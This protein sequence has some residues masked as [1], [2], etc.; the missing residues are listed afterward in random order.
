M[1]LQHAKTA[2]LDADRLAGRAGLGRG[3]L[4]RVEEA[5]TIQDGLPDE[6]QR[7][8]DAEEPLVAPLDA[9]VDRLALA[10]AG[11]L[12]GLDG[13]RQIDEPLGAPLAQQA[14]EPA[15]GRDLLG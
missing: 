3:A 12:G 15:C 4:P 1:L 6:A 2:K 9:D 13:E 10:L 14:E 5:L 8:L 11:A 7:D